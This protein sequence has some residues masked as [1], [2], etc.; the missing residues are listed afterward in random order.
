MLR[1]NLSDSPKKQTLAAE[2]DDEEELPV[3]RSKLRSKKKWTRILLSRRI[4]QLKR[5]R[6]TSDSR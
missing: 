5:R 4:A 6:P 3:P 1:A 2:V